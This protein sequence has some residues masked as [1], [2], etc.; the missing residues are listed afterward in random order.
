MEIKKPTGI[1]TEYT[2]RH[3][4]GDKRQTERESYTSSLQEVTD[5][6]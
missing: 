6:N 5:L 2:D 4:H 1:H 3:K